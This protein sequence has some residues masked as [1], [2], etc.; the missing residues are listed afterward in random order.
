MVSPSV[1]IETS[2]LQNPL[3][4]A[5]K[6]IKKAYVAQT[7]QCDSLFP[8]L[9][10]PSTPESVSPTEKTTAVV[11]IADCADGAAGG[12]ACD[13]VGIV[14]TIVTTTFYP[15]INSTFRAIPDITIGK[16]PHS[17]GFSGGGGCSRRI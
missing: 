11:A 2:H 3:Y 14:P 12:A 6:K 7:L 10:S 4:F 1:I 5:A 8:C 15:I 13:T 9:S 17:R 16:W